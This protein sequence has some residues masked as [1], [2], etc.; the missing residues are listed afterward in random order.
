[1]LC[2]SLRQ[3]TC[4]QN[5]IILEEQGLHVHVDM[6]YRVIPSQII[7]LYAICPLIWQN[8]VG[9]EPGEVFSPSHHLMAIWCSLGSRLRPRP[10]DGTTESQAEAWGEDTDRR[11]ALSAT[12]LWEK[13]ELN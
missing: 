7:M 9:G 11:R 6:Y 1:M 2:N 10:G 5:S 4:C 12:E 13:R 8:S 3:A